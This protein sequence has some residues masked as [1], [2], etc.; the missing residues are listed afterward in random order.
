MSIRRNAI[1]NYLGQGWV[2]VMGIAFVP[3]YVRILGVES[4]GLIGFFAVLQAAMQL[5]DFGLTPTLNREFARLASGGQTP[6]SIRD[7]LRS[8]EAVCAFIAVVMVGFIGAA[9]GWI[10]ATWLNAG[11]LPTQLVGDAVKIMGLVLA[12]RWLEQLY[13]AAL[14]GIGDQIWLNAAQAGLATLRWGGAYLVIVLAAPTVLAFFVWQGA[15]SLLT[16]V[17]LSA[18]TYHVLPRAERRARFNW[19]SLRGVSRFASGMFVGSILAFLLLQVDKLAISKLLPLEQFGYYMIAATAAGGLG[20]LI[21]PMNAAVYPVLTGYVTRGDD[22]GLTRSFTRACEWLTAIIV[23]PALILA[24]LPES[25]LLLWTGNPQLVA[26]TAPL[27]AVIALATLCNGLMNL[28]YMLQLAHG[29]TSL[30]VR[31]N[32]VAVATIVPAML[33]AVPRYGAIGAAAAYLILNLGYLAIG[34]QLMFRRLLPDSKRHW[35]RVAVLAPLAA[36]GAAGLA[37]RLMLGVPATRLGAAAEVVLA[38]FVL[39]LAVAAVMPYVRRSLLD[40]LPARG[41]WLGRWRRRTLDTEQE[42]RWI[43]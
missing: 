12:A 39:P 3:L 25:V 28:P 6:Q 35:Y 42:S 24:C 4:Y 23:P 21:T 1:A 22:L 20:Q 41:E 40:M 8:V 17:V 7:L 13:R 16:V 26:A 11:H 27:L 33:W 2:A 36:G 15:V 5:L 18:R 38:A 32:I 14:L 9:S 19:D 43:D 29:W 31:I 30:A 10:A 37:L 34:A